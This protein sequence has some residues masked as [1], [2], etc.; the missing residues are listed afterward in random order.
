MQTI[1]ELQQTKAEEND[2]IPSRVIGVELSPIPVALC[3]WPTPAWAHTVSVEPEDGVGEFC[4]TFDPL[5][6][7]GRVVI[8][9]EVRLHV[10]RDAIALIATPI[11]IHVQVSETAI[12]RSLGIEDAQLFATWMWDLD[13]AVVVPD[14]LAEDL[15]ALTDVEAA[16][17]RASLCRAI[18]AVDNEGPEFETDPWVEIAR[19][20]TEM[21]QVNKQLAIT[22]G[23]LSRANTIKQALERQL[24]NPAST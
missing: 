22:K 1:A 14:D 9:R 8:T 24:A 10:Y 15:R 21:G 19:L 6:G 3:R 13:T 7:T 17:L 23:R 20:A 4:A 2:S 11:V 16:A 12:V 18:Q 5:A